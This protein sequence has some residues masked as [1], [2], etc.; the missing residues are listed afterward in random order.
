MCVA[1]STRDTHDFR[2]LHRKVRELSGLARDIFFLDATVRGGHIVVADDGLVW[3]RL[4]SAHP[5]S[6]DGLTPPTV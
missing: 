4:R 1:E 5:R 2:D 3:G 6:V